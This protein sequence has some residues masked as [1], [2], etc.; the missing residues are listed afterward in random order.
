MVESHSDLF[1]EQYE[2]YYEPF[3]GAGAV[4]FHLQPKKGLVT[5]INEELIITYNAIKDSWSDIEK[6]LK[7]HQKKHCKEYYYQIRGTTYKSDI[8]KAARMIYLNRTCFNGIYR[9]NRMGKF[10]VPKGS[11]DHVI[12][13]DDDFES[14]SKILKR[15]RVECYDYT[16]AITRA[17][18]GDFL[19]CDPPYAIKEKGQGFLGY[20]GKRFDWEDQENLAQFVIHAKRR[21]VKILMTN[22]DDLNVRRLYED[23]PGFTF[24]E[25]TRNCTIAGGR[26]GRNR[27]KELIVKANY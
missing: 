2:K 21:G 13:A 23:E 16:R 22:V 5:D 27:Y 26:K 15:I 17:T 11:K 9:V 10:N 3:L 8:K 1:P 12:L 7:I 14:I 4:L 25:T 19:Y 24:V 18:Q 20:T 6:E